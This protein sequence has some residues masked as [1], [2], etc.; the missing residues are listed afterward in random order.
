MSKEQNQNSE[1]EE[2]KK[3]LSQLTESLVLNYTSETYQKMI[4]TVKEYS[5]LLVSGKN[6]VTTTQ[7]RNI[8]NSVKTVKNPETLLP[9][10][11]R[12]A[13]LA[14]RNESNYKFKALAD[15]LSLLIRNV[16]TNTQLSHFVEF[17]TALIAY[18]KYYEK[19][20]SK[21]H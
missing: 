21:K 9:L 12:L 10:Q 6:A 5:K 3:L 1:I 18:Q 15:R 8:Y 16:K 17:F 20:T 7:L 13:Y 11:V 14:G 4:D 19:F 2:E